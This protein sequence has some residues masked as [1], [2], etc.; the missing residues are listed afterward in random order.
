[1]DIVY[2]CGIRTNSPTAFVPDGAVGVHPADMKLINTSPIKRKRIRIG[3][4]SIAYTIKDSAHPAHTV[5]FIHGFPFNKSM[6]TPQ[7][8]ALP[9]EVRAIAIDV[10]GHGRSTMGH[11]YFSVDVFA[12]DLLVFIQKLQLERVVLCG[13]SMGGYIALRAFEIAPAQFSGLVLSDTHSQADDNATKQKRFDTIQSLL[14]HGKRVFSINFMENVLGERAR[15]EQPQI[16]ELI[17]QSIRRNELRSICSTL[18]ALA[19]RTD[20]T[21]SLANIHVPVLIVRGAEDGLATRAQ[22]DILAEHIPYAI[23]VEIPDCGHL[24]N[25]EDPV[26]FN[27][28]LSSFLRRID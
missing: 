22:A 3:D 10:R 17:K 23:Y 4:I 28:E 13:V 21:A 16:A 25:L 24:P 14:R 27:A 1:M 2:I 6:W 8:E 11:G 18:L 9:P 5:I 26:R 19:S 15:S 20:T 12:K 7:M